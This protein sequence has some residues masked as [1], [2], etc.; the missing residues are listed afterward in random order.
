LSRE[1]NYLRLM[2]EKQ[3]EFRGIFSEMQAPLN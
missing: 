3:S 1:V 2:Q